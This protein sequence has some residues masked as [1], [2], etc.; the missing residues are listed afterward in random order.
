[1]PGAHAEL[2][3]LAEKLKAPIVHALGG[4]EYVEWDNPYDVGMTGLIGFS[5]GYAAMQDCD[6]LV[7]LGTD[8]PYRQFFPAHAK[9]VQVDLRPENLGR[10][11]PLDLALVGDVKSTIEAVLPLIEAKSSTAYLDYCKKRYVSARRAG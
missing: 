2:L 1:M 10:R 3:K 11:V 8:F 5:S 7:M 6:T 4:K 9:V